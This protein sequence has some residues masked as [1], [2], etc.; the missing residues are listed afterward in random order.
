MPTDAD[1]ASELER[2][3][4]ELMDFIVDALS[5]R[6]ASGAAPDLSDKL[7]AA[8]ERRVDQR[9]EEAVERAI[10]ARL[11]KTSW[12]DPARFAEQVAAALP[13]HL[14]ERAPPEEK[15]S[16]RTMVEEA[17][18]GGRKDTAGL[19]RGRD[20]EAEESRPNLAQLALIV[21]IGLAAVAALVYFGMRWLNPA[22]SDPV[23][24]Q[25]PQVI[26]QPVD[27]VNRTVAPGNPA[28]PAP[29]PPANQ[30]GAR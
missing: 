21:V 2:L 6:M 11:A 4:T 25:E 15:R 7:V 1:A 22:P 29:A 26:S 9:T 28:Q 19:R 8:I 14:P 27:P 18:R 13:A 3:R 5:E 23:I 30:Q 10:E 24:V 17:P 20:A 16:G 12:P